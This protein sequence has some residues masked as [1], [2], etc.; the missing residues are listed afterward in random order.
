MLLGL[1]LFFGTH[2]FSMTSVRAGLVTRLGEKPYKGIYTVLS[3]AG[4][5]FII[6]G[7]QQ[8]D[9]Q[10]LWLPIN[11]Y[12]HLAYTFMPVACILIASAYIDCNIKRITKHPMLIGVLIWAMVHL[13]ANGDLASSAIFAS[14]ALYSI[15]G[16]VFGSSR[17]IPT[18]KLPFS[19]DVLAIGLGV[20]LFVVLFVCHDYITGISLY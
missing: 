16:I 19:G 12:K 2:L 14:F 18:I 8:T 6:K 20:C 1:T 4:L 9:Y 17:P 7:F 3:F 15:V 11:G 10:Q 5:Y 13:L